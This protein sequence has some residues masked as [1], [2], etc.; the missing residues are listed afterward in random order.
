MDPRIRMMNARTPEERL[1]ISIEFLRLD[2]HRETGML[3]RDIYRLAISP[4]LDAIGA[5]QVIC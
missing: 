1:A 2:H 5:G 3:D 4:Y